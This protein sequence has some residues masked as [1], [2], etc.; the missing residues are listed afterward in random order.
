MSSNVKVTLVE[1]GDVIQADGSW[2]IDRVASDNHKRLTIRQSFKDV[3]DP[4]APLIAIEGGYDGYYRPS[5]YV[6]D[7]E[8]PAASDS[9]GLI[10]K[11][12]VVSYADIVANEGISVKGKKFLVTEVEKQDKIQG[13]CQGDRVVTAQE[14]TDKNQI[15]PNGLTIQFTQRAEHSG[16]DQLCDVNVVGRMK[17]TFGAFEP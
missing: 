9:G 2:C 1:A 12:S 17:P 3:A 8:G 16:Y 13:H 11:G 6:V 15:D 10:I 14:L 5:E 4:N 7:R